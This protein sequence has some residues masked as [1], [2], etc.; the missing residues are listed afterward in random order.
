MDGATHAGA[1]RQGLVGGIDDGVQGEGR[2]VGGEDFDPLGLRARHG[3]SSF[4]V[5]SQAPAHMVRGRKSAST[6]QTKENIAVAMKT[7]GK[8]KSVSR[9][10]KIAGG[11]MLA[12]SR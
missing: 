5:G 11:T 8:G 10:A 2:D 3:R 9:I 6:Q 12:A 7:E 1:G 4:A